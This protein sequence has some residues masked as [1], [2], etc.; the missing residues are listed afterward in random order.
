MSKYSVAGSSRPKWR[1][2]IFR[3][4]DAGGKAIYEGKGGYDKK[5]EA[6]AAKRAQI[7]EL[8][9][10]RIEMPPPMPRKEAI[11]LQ[12]WVATWIANDAT[13]NCTPKTVERYRTLAAYLDSPSIPEIASLAATPISEIRRPALRAAF[14]AMLRMKAKRR[15]HVSVRTVRHVAA[16]VS[17]ARSE[18][19]EQELIPSN[20]MF[21]LKLPRNEKVETRSLTPEQVQALRDACRGDWTFTL[22][23]LAL[24]TGAR[25]GELLALQWADIDAVKQTVIISKSVE[26]TSAGLRVKSTK[27][28]KARRCTLPQSAMAALS[29]QRGQQAELKKAF[30][31]TYRDNDLVFAQ[32][33]GEY[34]VPD[35]VSQTVVR[36]LLKAGIQKASFHTLR[37]T[38]ASLLL[39]R[40]VPLPAVSA[41]LGHADPNITARIYSHA[42]PD[43]DRRGADTWDTVVETQVL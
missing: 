12:L 28:T 14:H 30:A 29:F 18:A 32:P 8:E 22:I 13:R 11:P 40:G 17:V 36:R 31:G 10:P 25:R 37:H 3:G 35:L 1:Y 27:S 9:R 15:S 4:R 26:Q 33:N 6:E 42:L 16:L 43:D 7:E 23:E 20:P 38:H 5:G 19:V 21:R 39:S 2:R 34:L 41:R 24:A